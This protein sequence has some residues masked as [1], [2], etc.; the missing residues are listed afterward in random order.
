MGF[1]SRDSMNLQQEQSLI[2]AVIKVVKIIL[3]NDIDCNN[4]ISFTNTHL[5]KH[6]VGPTA[7][8]LDN[9]PTLRITL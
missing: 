5:I 3:T 1:N 2:E 6:S 7:H 8:C 9:L 4:E